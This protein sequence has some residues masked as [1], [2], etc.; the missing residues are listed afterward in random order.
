MCIQKYLYC[1]Q[2]NIIFLAFAIILFGLRRKKYYFSFPFC[3]IMTRRCS[4]PCR[5]DQG[6]AGPTWGGGQV[7]SRAG[8][9]AEE[10]SG[11]FLLLITVVFVF[12][13]V[14]FVFVFVDVIVFVVDVNVDVDVDVDVDVEA[15]QTMCWTGSGSGIRSAGG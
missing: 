14:I 6:P 3:L 9:A 8:Q 2:N 5:R 10:A 12:G 7:H 13:D 11:Q 4:E 15:S 1:I